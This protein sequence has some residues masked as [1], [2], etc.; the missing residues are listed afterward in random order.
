MVCVHCNFIVLFSICWLISQ[1]PWVL[2]NNIDLP[3]VVSSPLSGGGWETASQIKVVPGTWYTPRG[4]NLSVSVRFIHRWKCVRPV[5]VQ[6]CRKQRKTPILYIS[7]YNFHD[8]NSWQM[9][10]ILKL[11]SLFLYDSYTML[12]VGSKNW[13][14]PSTR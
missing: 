8:D 1:R 13:S 3:C 5:P 4:P 2:D 14:V 10:L 6:R 7:A 9:Y 11:P 12:T